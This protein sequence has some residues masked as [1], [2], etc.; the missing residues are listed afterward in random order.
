MTI[1]TISSKVIPWIFVW[2]WST[3]FLAA[4]FGLPYAEPFTLLLYRFIFTLLFLLVVI[5]FK[6]SRWPR[7]KTEIFHL[8]VAGA[9]IHGVYLGG[10]F[11]AI[12][13]GMPAGLCAMMIGLQ[14]LGMAL[15]AGIILKEHVSRRQWMGLTIG[16]LGLYLV[17]FERLD[18]T[19]EFAFDG[20]P[21]WA[22]FA[23]IASLF[24]ISIGAVYQKR[25]CS[26]MDLISGT[27]IQYFS[28]LV[29]CAFIVV[30]FET[31][32][33][34]WT[35]P[36][37]LTLAWQVLALSVGAI[38]LLMTIIKQG[39]A[40]SVGSYFYLVAPL[41]AIQAWFLF[42]ETISLIS[43]AGVI[44]ISFGVAITS[45]KKSKN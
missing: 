20:F 5:R 44:L 18:L 27:W 19:S 28:A 22:I 45:S 23:V 7:S 1:L 6:K 42:G 38:L 17:L 13:W 2:I 15:M 37:I 26:D 31:G 30:L 29:F 4:K 36:F 40:A 3:G 14:P 25:F 41:V 34:S 43:I 16:L 39:A 32:E 24:G 21:I 8:M 11:Q 12:K 9:L 35:R 10:V 33:V